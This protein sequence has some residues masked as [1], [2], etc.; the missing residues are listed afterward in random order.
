M[1]GMPSLVTGIL[2]IM[3]EASWLNSTPC[4]QLLAHRDK[5]ADLFESRVFHFGRD[6]R[7]KSVLAAPH[8]RRRFREL[9]ATLTDLPRREAFPRLIGGCAEP[10]EPFLF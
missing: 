8:S 6:A 2:T 10:S 7:R 4:P 9:L 1:A 3:L 5:V